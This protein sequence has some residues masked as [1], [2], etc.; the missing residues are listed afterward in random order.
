MIVLYSQETDSLVVV[1]EALDEETPYKLEMQYEL[2]KEVV[3]TGTF[4][5]FALKADFIFIGF[6]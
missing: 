4:D 2:L 3:A 5:L 1:T 6:L